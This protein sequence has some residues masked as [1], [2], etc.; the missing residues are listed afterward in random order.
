MESQSNS[1]LRKR[2]SNFGGIDGYRTITKE[3]FCI[4]RG[5]IL[6]TKRQREKWKKRDRRNDEP[7]EGFGNQQ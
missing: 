1:D 3:S 7:V 2:E 6:S 4:L 5:R